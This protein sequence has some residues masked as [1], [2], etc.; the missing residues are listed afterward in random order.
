MKAETFAKAILIWKRRDTHVW[1]ARV[2]AVHYW[3]VRAAI[4]T[5]TFQ[6]DLPHALPYL[7]EGRQ[8]VP[9]ELFCHFT[10]CHTQLVTFEQVFTETVRE[11]VAE[12]AT[13]HKRFSFHSMIHEVVIVHRFFEVTTTC[14]LLYA[15]VSL[16]AVVRFLLQQTKR[17]KNECM[18]LRLNTKK[19]LQ[20][21]QPTFSSQLA[22]D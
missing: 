12:T 21:S 2:E 11:N 13:A 18:Y 3:L 5:D 19:C 10:N 17:K 1:S 7:L 22:Q 9:E 8:V 20:S 6:A 14:R 4:L 16:I 15:L